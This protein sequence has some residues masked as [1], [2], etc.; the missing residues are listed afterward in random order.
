MLQSESV[1]VYQTSKNTISFT[2][3]SPQAH[4]QD[5]RTMSRNEVNSG[6]RLTSLIFD[7]KNGFLMYQVDRRNV[8]AQTMNSFLPIK[9]RLKGELRIRKSR[10][11]TTSSKKNSGSI[12]KTVGISCGR[13]ALQ[14]D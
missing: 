6:K 4:E 10:K 3:I 13:G 5:L 12:L 14:I 11:S 9:S 7:F 2:T 1:A 8:S